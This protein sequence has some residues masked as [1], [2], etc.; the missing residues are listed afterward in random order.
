MTRRAAR[1]L[2]ALPE[3]LRESVLET[4]SAIE[5]DP[6]GVGK[7][8][9]GRLAGLWSSRVGSYRVIYSIERR[10]VVV[11]AIRHRGTAYR[12]RRRR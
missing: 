8:L 1:D 7:Q 2:D 10:Q 9:V 3:R 11:R 6:E 12:R 5:I 4:L